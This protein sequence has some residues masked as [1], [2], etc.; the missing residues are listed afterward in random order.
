[1]VFNEVEPEI[2]TLGN[3]RVLQFRQE[4]FNNDVVFYNL[5][6]SGNIST[7]RD[8]LQSLPASETPAIILM[9]LEQSFFNPKTSA[10]LSQTFALEGARKTD[11]LAILARSFTDFMSGK[12]RR[13]VNS[14]ACARPIGLDAKFNQ[15]GFR[16][17]GSRQ[18]GE[19]L[20]NPL[21]PGREDFE[22]KDSF[23]RIDKGVNIFIKGGEV[24]S[25]RLEELKAFLIET[26][27]R[28][29]HIIAFLPPYAPT[30]YA[31]M[32]ALGED[33]TYLAELDDELKKIFAETR[34]RYFNFS[35][36][37]KFGASDKEFIDGIHGSEKAYLRL[38]I[39]MAEQDKELRNRTDPARIKSDLNLTPSDL[40]VYPCSGQ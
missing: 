3:S 29:I 39:T 10:A 34:H 2:T 16:S 21:D 33:Y 1:M 24:D 30:V 35:D 32:M 25:A 31:K 6:L 22:F 26:E 20:A 23:E 11:Y 36:A 27:N 37:A 28:G 8:W 7:Y 9:G 5:A 15:N 4:F 12:F 40:E 38:F 14:P 13:R 19:I 18:N 17:D